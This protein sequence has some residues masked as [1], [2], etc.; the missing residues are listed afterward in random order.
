M[1]IRIQGYLQINQFLCIFYFL[2]HLNFSLE[3]LKNQIQLQYQFNQ[4]NYHYFQYNSY[5][6]L[7]VCYLN[8]LK[9]IF[10]I[11]NLLHYQNLF[12]MHLQ[13][14]QKSQVYYLYNS[15][16]S[17]LNLSKLNT[18]YLCQM[19][20]K[21]FQTLLCI[22]FLQFLISRNFQVTNQLKFILMLS[23]LCFVSCIN[24]KLNQ[25]MIK[26]IFR[27]HLLTFRYGS[28]F[29]Q[30][31]NQQTLRFKGCNK[32]SIQSILSILLIQQLVKQQDLHFHINQRK[33][34]TV[35]SKNHLLQLII[36][37]VVQFKNK[38]DDL[39][40]QNYQQKMSKLKFK[41]IRLLVIF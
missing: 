40:N 27:K 7:Q 10:Q 22:T 8:Y 38:E 20:I 35:N 30:L 1:P 4:C 2:F 23:I 11:N 19:L 29:S 5:Q 9:Q 6:I 25:Y 34:L 12:Q 17:Y 24:L 37:Q 41:M 33:Q 26:L 39:H 21:L 36:K 14:L 15:L 3:D 31:K 28:L 16:I 13:N 18:I 32:F